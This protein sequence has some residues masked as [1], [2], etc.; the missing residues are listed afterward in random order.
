MTNCSNHIWDV[1]GYLLNMRFDISLIEID[2]HGNKMETRVFAGGAVIAKQKRAIDGGQTYDSIEWLTA[3]PV[4]GTEARFIYTDLGTA[5][6]TE[7]QEPLGQQVFAQDPAEFPDP[8]P[9][10]MV[11]FWE[12]MQWQCSIPQEFYGGFEEMPWH[13]QNSS[14]LSRS[15]NGDKLYEIVEGESSPKKVRI[16]KN[17]KS[18]PEGE[19]APSPSEKI[20]SFSLSSSTKPIALDDDEDEIIAVIQNQKTK[21]LT[22]PDDFKD[23][24]NSGPRIDPRLVTIVGDLRK[25]VQDITS[26]PRCAWALAQ[27][28]GSLEG[29]KMKTKDNFV[30]SNGF[31]EILDLFDR[32]K[33]IKISS[34]VSAKAD[35]DSERNVRI[36]RHNPQSRENAVINWYVTATIAEIIHT[37]KRKG[38]YSDSDLDKAA[39]IALE[40]FDAIGSLSYDGEISR[41]EIEIKNKTYD[42]GSMGHR[43]VSQYCQYSEEEVNRSTRLP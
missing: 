4:T 12:D 31:T 1:K 23:A 11:S 9:N 34:S 13:C 6:A 5:R 7:E 16:G 19:A 28:F 40:D 25:R 22:M 37:A 38:N 29:M 17:P 39:L 35:V 8:P 42:V 20:L 21:A 41:R 36:S 15:L 32:L 2:Q 24:S 10:E 33:S 14:L 26:R 30:N 43:F 3:D 27:F 18:D